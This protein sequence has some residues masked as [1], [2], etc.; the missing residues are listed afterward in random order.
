MASVSDPNEAERLMKRL[1]DRKR[2]Y[3]EYGK[4]VNGTNETVKPLKGM[5]GEKTIDG[6]TKE[7]KLIA[8]GIAV[9]AFPDPTISD[10]VGA[11]M[12]AAGLIKQK[13]KPLT[14]T[15]VCDEFQKVAKDIAKL[16]KEIMLSK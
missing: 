9:I 4:I 1:D 16:K 2:R 8:A 10:L 7:S 6:K 11:G 5:V 13:T 15:D 14:A 3:E 12:V